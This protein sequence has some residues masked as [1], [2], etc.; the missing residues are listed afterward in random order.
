MN[1][2]YFTN[3]SLTLRMD[4]LLSQAF[5]LV[6]ALFNNR[7]HFIFG[8]SF[9]IYINRPIASLNYQ[10]LFYYWRSLSASLDYRR[11][12]AS[13][14]L[15]YRRD[16]YIYV[17][18]LLAS[19]DYRRYFTIGVTWLSALLYLSICVTWLSASLDYRRY[20]TIGVTSLFFLK[21][22]RW[23]SIYLTIGAI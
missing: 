5:T 23:F 18:W 7:R 4:K 2:F 10:W 3:P 12:L 13:T 20:F 17:I 9:P 21:N 1:E 16:L 15:N 8:V 19:L 6:S 22:W 14:L 11:R